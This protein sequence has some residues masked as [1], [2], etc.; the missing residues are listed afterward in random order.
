[1]SDPRTELNDLPGNYADFL[2]VKYN[3]RG[4]HDP[5]GDLATYFAESFEY[6][7]NQIGRAAENSMKKTIRESET[8][9]GKKRM[10]GQSGKWSFK[11]YGRS[12]GREETGWM[13][14]SVD[15]EITNNRNQNV[16]SFGWI[17]WDEEYF[18]FQEFGFQGIQIMAGVTGDM[19]RFKRTSKTY[20]VEGMGS[21]AKALAVVRRMAP[22][23]A[24]GVMNEAIRKLNSKN[25]TF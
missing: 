23:F 16:V 6:G 5:F 14:D 19:P 20:P 25:G 1:M 3:A 10:T 9:W 8:Q 4:K 24:Q 2:S 17:N 15:Y 21:L 7:L 11:P 13:Y 12:T 18:A 22:S